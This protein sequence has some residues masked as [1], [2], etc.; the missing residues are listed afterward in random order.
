[1][2]RLSLATDSYVR[3]DVGGGVAHPFLDQPASGSLC[4]VDI[5]GVGQHEVEFAEP[6]LEEILPFLN[7]VNT[8]V[9]RWPEVGGL[10]A[11]D[12]SVSRALIAQWLNRITERRFSMTDTVDVGVLR[13]II[14]GAPEVTWQDRMKRPLTAQDV[15]RRCR[16]AELA[17]LLRAGDAV[18]L[19]RT[20]H[21]QLPSGMHS[22]Y[23]IRAAH[24]IRSP[25]DA[26]VLATWLVERVRKDYTGFLI[27]TSSL[28]AVIGQL[29][30]VM[31]QADRPLGPTA[32]LSS[33]PQTRIDVVRAVQRAAGRSGP[34]VALLSVSSSGRVRD[35]MAEAL[36]AVVDDRWSLDILVDKPLVRARNSSDDRIVSWLGLSDAATSAADARGCRLCRSEERATV[37]EIDPRSYEALPL[38]AN[39]LF[40]PSHHDAWLNRAFWSLASR[41]R[42][43]AVEARPYHSRSSPRPKRNPLALRIMLDRILDDEAGLLASIRERVVDLE[44][45]GG[46]G[47]PDLKRALEGA[48]HAGVV[49]AGVGDMTSSEGE[50]RLPLL[51]RVLGA[52]GIEPRETVVVDPDGRS[53]TRPLTETIRDD[54][55]VLVFSWGSV[56]GWSLTR[57]LTRIRSEL[58]GRALVHGLAM[59]ARPPS[60]E[61]WSAARTRF[62]PGALG[63]LWRT[64]LPLESPLRDEADLVDEFL[65][66]RGSEL[67]DSVIRFLKQRLMVA[68]PAD[69]VLE[70]SVRE[71]EFSGGKIPN[72]RGVFWASSESG[73]DTFS[74]IL[75]AAV[76]PVTIYA[77]CAAAVHHARVTAQ[78]TVQLPLRRFDMPAIIRSGYT[79][80]EL[81]ALL[82]W[83]RPGEAWW[84]SSQTA[85][86]ALAREVLSDYRSDDNFE[87]LLAELMI[88]ASLGK[89][90]RAAIGEVEGA[91][92]QLPNSAVE[93]AVGIDLARWSYE[94]PS[95]QPLLSP[96][97]EQEH[98]AS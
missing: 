11:T 98:P 21:Y 37:V 83:V 78:E 77:A 50:T 23:F 86:V 92:R 93:M 40:I 36:S 95:P 53:D 85:Q 45:L 4:F 87:V 39:R 63:A 29:Q 74:M 97:P 1:M 13:F 59:H 12:D 34:I 76:D 32:V 60:P 25:R 51:S 89:L 20:Y 17:A 75:G 73:E 65:G 88:A 82:R 22:E 46:D 96:P 42:A 3:I 52:L 30:V 80:L 58:G 68:R 71:K 2:T 16:S 15:I 44:K 18:W 61:D 6:L 91:A 55:T 70:W 69:S 9:F 24:A 48:R 10:S 64:Y 8:V 56:T 35:L 19:P 26:T 33:Y 47:D 28:T 62:A 38:D 66:D 54:D 14:G 27:D 31:C 41:N 79:A 67:S 94:A 72:P 84:G 90:P 5:A 7:H 81:A 57:L 43:L 49:V